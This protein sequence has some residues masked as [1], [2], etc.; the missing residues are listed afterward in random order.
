MR[1]NG[2]VAV[3]VQEGVTLC[4]ATPQRPICLAVVRDTLNPAAFSYALDEPNVSCRIEQGGRVLFEG[5]VR[6]IVRC[7][8]DPP[9]SGPLTITLHIRETA[10]SFAGCRLLC[11]SPL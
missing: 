1:A 3:E 7:V 8:P 4:L 5:D 9:E 10:S 11:G 2:F 6:R